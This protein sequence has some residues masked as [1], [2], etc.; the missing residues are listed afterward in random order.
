MRTGL[1]QISVTVGDFGGNTQKII[2]A[3]EEAKSL[4]VDLPTFPELTFCGY[5]R[6]DLLLKLEFIEQKKKRGKGQK[7]SFRKPLSLLPSRPY[8]TDRFKG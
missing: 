2:A 7:L 6:E 1:A 8:R 4:G 5:P 3:M